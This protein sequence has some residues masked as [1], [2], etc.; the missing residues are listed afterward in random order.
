MIQTLSASEYQESRRLLV[1]S[2]QKINDAKLSLALYVFRTCHADADKLLIYLDAFV[3][4]TPTANLPLNL[5]SI[6]QAL[7]AQYDPQGQLGD[8]TLD[9][10]DPEHNHPTED[11]YYVQ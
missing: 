7:D 4:E 11:S 1:K 5:Q 8:V 6:L 9:D 2:I 10:Y 3:T